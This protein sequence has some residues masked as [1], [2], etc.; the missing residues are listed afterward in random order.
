MIN[1]PDDILNLAIGYDYKD[2]S[3]RLSMLYQS[4]IFK[5]TDFWTELRQITDDYIRWD[6]SMKQDLPWF[7][8]QLFANV[9]NLTSTLDRDLNQGSLFPAAEQHYGWALD[10]GIRWKN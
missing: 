4:N 10:I 7:G 5:G 1:Q 9:I 3:I 2:L 6:I 8:L